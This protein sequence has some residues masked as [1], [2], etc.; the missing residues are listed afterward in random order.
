MFGVS[1]ALL[2]NVLI[3][4]A[5][6]LNISPAIPIPSPTEA[7]LPLPPNKLDSP[8]VFWLL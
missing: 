7:V 1:L 6:V 5:K 8:P 4:G 3:R 2:F